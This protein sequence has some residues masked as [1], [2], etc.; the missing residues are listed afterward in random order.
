MAKRWRTFKM[1]QN[2]T[3][4]ILKYYVNLNLQRNALYKG[5]K[6]YSLHNKSVYIKLHSQRLWTVRAYTIKNPS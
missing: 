6:A 4:E 1:A 2:I 3:A 5:Y